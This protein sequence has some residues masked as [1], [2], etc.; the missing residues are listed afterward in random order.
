MTSNLYAIS[1]LLAG[2]NGA[3]SHSLCVL[4][5]ESEDEAKIKAINETVERKPGFEVVETLCTEIDTTA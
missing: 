1:C 5:S 3:T 4:E 2:P